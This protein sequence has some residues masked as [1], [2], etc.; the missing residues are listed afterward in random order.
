MLKQENQTV[1]NFAG[2][3]N[4]VEMKNFRMVC[5]VPFY[6]KDDRPRVYTREDNNSKAYFVSRKNKGIIIKLSDIYT[7]TVA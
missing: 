4:A 5:I 2:F 1:R 3:V 7:R 6:K